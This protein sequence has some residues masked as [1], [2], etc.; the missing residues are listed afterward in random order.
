MC[1]SARDSSSARK[2]LHTRISEC[3]RGGATGVF[4]HFEWSLASTRQWTGREARPG[5]LQLVVV[6]QASSPVQYRARPGSSTKSDVLLRRVGN[7]M[8]LSFRATGQC[9]KAVWGRLAA[10]APIGNR[11]PALVFNSFRRV[12]NPPQVSNLPHNFRRIPAFGK[13]EWHWA[14]S[15]RPIGNRP[16]PCDPQNLEGFA[17]RQPGGLG[18]RVANP[19]QVDNLPH[20]PADRG[21]TRQQ[22]D[23]ILGAWT[24]IN[25]DSGCAPPARWR[26]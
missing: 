25:R 12:N 21:A 16:F 8:P 6:E 3:R 11:R 19:P 1:E 9:D 4:R 10:C 23:S 2:A 7:P 14:G 20:S 22:I 24:S 15:L 5:G 26:C 17:G 18:R 13:T